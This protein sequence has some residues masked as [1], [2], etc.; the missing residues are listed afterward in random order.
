MNTPGTRFSCWSAISLVTEAFLAAASFCEALIGVVKR[1]LL[2]P[3]AMHSMFLGMIAA[4]L[5]AAPRIDW[6]RLD[7]PIRAAPLGCLALVVTLKLGDGDGDRMFQ[8]A[9]VPL[10]SLACMFFLMSIV[11]GAPEAERFEARWLK[12]LGRLSYSI[13]LL[14]VPVLGLMHGFVL[15]DK[16]DVATPAQWLVTLAALPVSTLVGWAIIL[17]AAQET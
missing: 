7:W 4:V 16:P 15:G 5:L 6:A 1:S 11:R 3:A 12:V 14:H 2:L 10:V 13:Y 17:S 8:V 9:G